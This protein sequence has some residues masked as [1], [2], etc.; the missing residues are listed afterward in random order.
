VRNNARFADQVDAVAAEHGPE[1]K[2]EILAGR[3]KVADF[4]PEPEPE[5]AAQE[6]AP[7]A[8][9]P[10][11]VPEQP[12]ASALPEDDP[13]HGWAK[14]TDSDHV[15]WMA[16]NLT[17]TG[18]SGLRPGAVH[19]ADC[20]SENLVDPAEAERFAKSYMKHVDQLEYHIA[21]LPSAIERDAPDAGRR[22]TLKQILARHVDALQAILSAL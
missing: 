13:L 9:E 20:A 17:P 11:S 12:S 6:E 5:P 22:E 18:D 8:P 15:Q 2:A 16:R 10:E 7:P 3:K 19:I 1:A 21:L 14:Q 4:I